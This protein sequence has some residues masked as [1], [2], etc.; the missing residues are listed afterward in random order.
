MYIFII[1]MKISY[2]PHT[3]FS[4]LAVILL[5]T[6]SASLHSQAYSVTS[7]KAIRNFEK[8]REHFTINDDREAESYLRKALKADEQ[9]IEAWFMLAQIFLD[10]NETNKAADYYLAGV[11]IDPDGYGHGYLKVAELKFSIGHY[12][13]A[14]D[15]LDRWK[16]YSISDPNSIALAEKL[17]RDLKFAI[18]ALLKPVAFNPVPLG[19]A[20]NTESF[21]YWPA[22][23]IDEKTIFF[24]V[25]GPPNPE[26]PQ[27]KLKMQE[28]FYF[29]T[30]DSEHWTD[31]T[32]L[33]P[34]VNTNT[35]EGAQSV[36]ADGKTMYYTACDRSD[37]YG[38]CDIYSSSVDE[39]GRWSKPLN[40]GEPVNSW[41]SDKHP[42]IS[43]DGRILYFTSDRPGG[44]GDYDLWVSVNSG[45]SWSKPVNL[46]DSI[47][48][49]GTEQSPF[50]HPDQRSLYFS[51]DGWPGMGNGDIFLSRQKPNGTWGSPVNLGFPVNTHNEEIGLIVNARGDRAYYSSNRR[52]GTD[53]DIFTFTMPPGVK[54]DPVSYITGR[55]F[56]SR[57]MKGIGARFELI[58]LE[59][60][61]LVMEA[62]SQPG[63]G[64]YLLSLPTGEGYALNVSQPGYLFY[65]DHF[66]LD[67]RYDRLNPLRK[68]IPLDPVSS[69][70]SVILNNIFYDVDSYFLTRRSS[71]ELD[72]I[73]KF[74]MDNRTVR[75]EISGHTDSTGTD[76]YNLELSGKRA[77]QVVDYLTSRG[78]DPERLVA[79]GY[80][81]SKPVADNATEEGRAKNRRTEL[82]IISV[83]DD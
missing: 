13:E 20:V 77:G 79:K 21:E 36:T 78:I 51:S 56:D 25:L 66:E 38:R 64:D 74:L 39:E 83:D 63:D 40:L 73:Y 34:P 7:R 42:S 80:G 81:S 37:G 5:L 6:F 18:E 24:T 71:A 14:K 60:G 4:L 76:K 16:S 54:P 49:P 22:L 62:F 19:D 23:S 57:N 41:Y 69:G 59:T 50:I 61:K 33:G 55:V 32:Y 58:G 43:A 52:A 1:N 35:N 67:R 46:G 8:A 11:S 30:K 31:R 53:T 44:K 45:G 28:D 9:F 68:D 72:K 27:G 3:F 29:A 75:I 10:R 47:N 12:K 82:T 65:S 17:E 70:T 2:I 15:H 26:L 48:T